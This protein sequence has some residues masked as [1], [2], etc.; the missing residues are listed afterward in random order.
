M[1]PILIFMISLGIFA[2]ACDVAV[3]VQFPH[4]KDSS[5]L[6][7]TEPLP[8]WT[9]RKIEGVYQVTDGSDAF[10]TK[11]VLKW[12]GAGLS[13]FSEKNAAYLVLDCGRDGA[14]I[15]LEGY[16]RYAR[17]VETGL[18]RLMIGSEDGGSD[19]LADTTTISEI[20]ISGQYGNGDENPRHDLKLSYLRPFSEK[21]DQDKFYIIAHRGGGRTA[22]YLP[23]SENSLE[24]I[25]LASQ[26]GANA[27]EIDVKLSKDGVPFIYHDKTIN[28]RLVRKTTIL[29]YIEAF[30]FPQIR[31]LLTLVNGEKIPTLREAL[32]FVLTQSAIEVVWL[33]M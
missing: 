7:G 27:I 5:I 33:D 29:G 20:I 30:T 31:S 16:W 18:V 4:F 28:L 32:E 14:D 22:D 1:K 13:V 24:V 12:T 17:N 3:N 15:H 8:E 21:V 23:A 2:S 19:L 10:G 26:L 25:K 6:T 9:Q 11:V